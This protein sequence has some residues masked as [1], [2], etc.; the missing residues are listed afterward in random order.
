[1]GSLGIDIHLASL[2]HMMTYMH[3]DKQ[4][5]QQSVTLFIL[6]IAV[7]ILVYGPLSD[8]V[9]RRP[10]IFFGLIVAAISN[11]LIAAS[12]DV[13]TFLW[14]RVLQG[15]G[16]GVC[17]GL[18]RTIAADVMQGEKLAS[19]GPYFSMFLALSPMLAPALGGHMQHWFGWQSNFILLGCFTFLV[20]FILV[21]FLDETNHY[22]NPSAFSL[23]NICMQ[24]AGFFK[25]RVFLG[26]T[27][28]TGIV[29]CA[30]IIYMS[31]SSF[32]FQSEFHTTPIVF[33]WLTAM[34]GAASIVGKLIAPFIIIRL[35]RYK[36]LQL[37][38]GVMVFSGVF[39]S[40]FAFYHRS[41]ISVV[42]IGV[43]IAMFA[44]VLMSGITMAMALSPF[45][46]KRGTAAALYGSFQLLIPF[47]I[48]ALLAA[49]PHP[50]VM[51]LALS[52]VLLGVVGFIIYRTMI[53]TRSAP[54][55]VE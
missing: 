30:N 44:M 5:M 39:M 32:I 29:M 38:L 2:P 49:L 14:L 9:G 19:V 33:G 52:Y 13:N 8:R 31:I 24:Y 1:M 23:Q 11:F 53:L 17:W 54:Q 48:T 22:K 43:S 45:H 20:L 55:A 16:S 15:I 7:S 36:T 4:H 27:L 42:I 3:T 12:H 18:G 34:V 28:L 37:G 50:G 46:D 26:C 47:V 6:G 51:T 10:V 40:G 35:K 25:H 21:L 41:S